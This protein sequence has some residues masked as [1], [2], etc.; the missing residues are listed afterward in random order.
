MNTNNS[1]ALPTPR[2]PRTTPKNVIALNYATPSFKS[3][4]FPVMRTILFTLSVPYATAL[5]FWSVHV[6]GILAGVRNY[7][8]VW[9]TILLAIAIAVLSLFGLLACFYRHGAR[10][11]FWLTS[12][13]YLFIFATAYYAITR[14]PGG[15]DGPGMGWGLT[16]IPP[17]IL[18]AFV[19]F[20]FLAL[21]L[22][23][24]LHHR[25]QR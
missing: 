5:A 25:I 21:D 20:V 12:I 14:W 8:F 15:D 11:I 17:T 13:G 9:P 7:W 3:A 24:A 19:A 16:V 22:I 4:F 2:P 23:N 18:S 1:P 6:S 10:P